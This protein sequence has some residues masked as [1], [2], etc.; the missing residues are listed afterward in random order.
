VDPH[1]LTGRR[2][3]LVCGQ[4]GVG[5][6][7]A[8]QSPIRGL[9]LL[10]RCSRGDAKDLVKRPARGGVGGRVVRV[11][12]RQIRRCS[13][14]LGRSGGEGLRWCELDAGRGVSGRPGRA[15]NGWPGRGV[16]GWPGRESWSG[17]SWTGW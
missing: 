15:V 9:D 13:V 10:T 8:R 7:R 16:S 1:E 3:L 11:V 2:V 4:H 17:E 5:V 6:G 14:V 12:R